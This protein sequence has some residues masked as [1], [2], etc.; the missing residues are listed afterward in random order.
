MTGQRFLRIKP[1]ILNASVLFLA[2]LTVLTALASTARAQIDATNRTVTTSNFVVA[3]NTGTDTEAIISIIWGGGANLTSYQGLGTCFPSFPGSIEYFGNSYA[4]PD[5][6]AGGLVLVGGGTTTPTGTTAWSG[7]VLP[8]GT[9]QVTINSSSTGCPP[10][11]AGINVQTTYS[12]FNPNDASTN[13]FGVQR[14]FDFT[15]TTFAHDF[16]PYMARLSLSEG[17]TDVLYP[18][19]GGALAT[20]SVYD[21]GFGCT[22]PVVIPDA[23]PLN[24]L[25]DATQGW[26]AIHNPDTLQGVVVKRN[27][28]VDPQGNPIAVQLWV[29]ND[30]GSNTNVSSFLLMSPT[31]GFT[32]G[33]VT[34]V[35]TLCFYDSSIWTPS[36]TPPAGCSGSPTSTTLTSSLNPSN[37]GQTVTFTASVSST[38]GTP[39]GTVTFTDSTT[40]TTLGSA[41]L[42]SG[43]AS[44]STSSLAAG[45][46]SITAAY[47]GSSSFS[48]STS[49]PLNQVVNG[50]TTTTA[51]VSSL[52]PSVYG[53]AVTFTAAVSSASG[54]PTGTVIFTD[55]STSTTLGGATLASGSASLSTS[56]LAAGTHSI[57]AAYQASGSFSGSTS[58]PLSQKVNI[59]TTI[60]SLSSSLNPASTGQSV[61]FSATV[62]SQYGGTA[63]GSVT[64]LSGS[65]TLGTGT[66]S[67]NRATVSTSFT[68]A[69]TDSISAKYSGDTNNAGS[70]SPTLSQVII[71]AT[72]TALTSSL[73]PSVVGQAVTFTATVSSTAGAPPNGETV[74]FY[75]G[76]A[77]LGTAA[78]SAGVASLTTSSLPVGTLTM[79]ATYAGDA[80]FAASTSPGL[81]QVVNSTTKSATSTALVSSLNPSIYGQKVTWTATVTTSGSATPTGKVNFTWD[82]YSIGTATLNASG[83]A[84]LSK[85]NL[86]VYTYPLTAV[87]AGDAN[88]VGSTS[89]ILNQVVKETTS[90]AT[91]SSSANPSTEGQ[92]VTFTATIT[93]PTVTATGPVTFTAGKTVL[94]TA[95]LSGHKATFTT[96]TLAVGST[97]VT[98]TYS[99]DSNIAE[100]S[101]SVMQTVQP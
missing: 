10:S 78:L 19:I 44:L 20:L 68:T 22:G 67:G 53:Q 52:N 40:S 77:V 76:S 96:S 41:T 61:T 60:T 57:T 87:Y 38:A 47:Q 97:T 66:L 70:T 54:T 65:Q 7:Q 6:W 34:E 75:N 62:T 101:A 48:G 56:S 99:G 58:G 89:A 55:A 33:L 72:T 98:A 24:P 69:G 84:T 18:A 100:S 93:S 2:V 27:P 28:S 80:N 50:V 83:I 3:W 21:C 35:E 63:T 91:L 81:R 85:S 13:S 73:N 45:S 11:S 17:F 92:A 86:N 90:S 46:Q 94:G 5:P 37:Y 16:R 95:E 79:T 42:A 31:G 30:G 8:S 64:F 29:D 49:T 12:F 39:A 15:T 36:L 1:R 32:G 9:D 4:P 14:A 23:A 26:F 88:N 71:N 59:A 25:W 74:T 43:S 82:G 51:L